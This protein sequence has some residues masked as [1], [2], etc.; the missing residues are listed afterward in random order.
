MSNLRY[1]ELWAAIKTR[2]STAKMQRMLGPGKIYLEGQDYSAPEAAEGKLWGRLVIVPSVS[3]WP[4]RL[5]AMAQTRHVAFLVR[6]E[7]SDFKAVGFDSQVLLDA[8]QEEVEDQLTGWQPPD[9]TNIWAAL[10]VYIHAG[11]QPRP[12]WDDKRSLH[13]VSSHYRLEVAKR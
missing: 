13:W 12:M 10:P 6:S 3:L 7:I 5:S 9:M 1:T 11:A 2:L 4:S 8:I